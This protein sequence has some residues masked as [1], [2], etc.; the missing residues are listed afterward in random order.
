MS[1]RP[2]D[3]TADNRI[4]SHS[5]S[6]PG[7]PLQDDEDV[8]QFED[9]YEDEFES[10]DEIMEAGVD[11]RPDAEREVEEAE[12]AMQID[13][14]NQTFMVGRNKLSKDEILEPDETAYEMLHRLE[15]QWP[16]LSFDVLRDHLGEGRARKKYPATVYSVAGTQAARGHDKENEILVMKMS[17]LSRTSSDDEN[18][19]S[20][21][22]SD[23]DD[24]VDADPIL[25]TKRIPIGT[26]TNRIR[27]Y[28]TPSSQAD[29][30]QP[31]KTTLTATMT[32]SG[33]VFIHDITP[34]LTSFDTPGTTI[35]S[36]QDKPIHTI[37]SHKR[38]EGYA[39]DWRKPVSSNAAHTPSLLTG[40]TAGN[41]YHTTVSPSGQFTTNSTP[42]KGHTSSVEELH[43][44]PSEATVFASASAD[45]T[46]RIW[47]T[48][49]RQQKPQLS[50]TASNTDVNVLAWSPLTSYLLASGHDDGSFSV[51]DLRSWQREPKKEKHDPI[52]AFDFHKEQITSLEWHPSDDSILAACAGDDT[53]SLWDL[54]VELDDEE[55]KDTAGVAD[56]PP[57]L[58]FV[59][60]AEG[61]K[62]S[63]WLPQQEGALMCTGLGGFGVW[64]SISV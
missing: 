29:P 38:H 8:G 44:S 6:R 52:A 62:E 2:A 43:W 15:P 33:S 42:F 49:A 59:H 16:C 1:K 50:V 22:D 12:N 9:E 11:G 31:F 51:W 58:L 53:L 13:G 28:Q 36:Q 5:G 3:T 54:A 57:Q 24:D 64:R 37:T 27:A 48:R 41:I 20:E 25:E 17:K 4:P 10:E 32:E 55:S 40:D 23:D 35:T 30:L 56:V 34:H 19:D 47:D 18:S 46:V 7:A 21:S 39:L 61:V 26:V 14:Q 45:H 60:Y 63:H